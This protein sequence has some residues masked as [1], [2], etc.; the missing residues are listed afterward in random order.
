MNIVNISASR[1]YTRYTIYENVQLN[2][3][4][5]FIVQEAAKFMK[6][7]TKYYDEIIDKS[8]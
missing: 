5:C 7:A 2:I 6:K 3:E 1:W 4:T 8:S